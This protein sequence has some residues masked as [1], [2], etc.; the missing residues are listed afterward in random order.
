EGRVINGVQLLPSSA[1][2]VAASEYAWG[3]QETMNAIA[4]VAEAMRKVFAEGL[5]LRVSHIGRKDGG[6]LRGH[7]SHQSGR[8]VDIG[9]YYKP[10]VDPARLTGRREALVDP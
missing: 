4:H 7:F 9:F 10:G 8:D 3:T 5:P 6:Y 1:V 2:H